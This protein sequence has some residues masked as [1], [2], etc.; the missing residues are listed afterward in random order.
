MS[1]QV[2]EKMVTWVKHNVEQSP[3]LKEM[4]NYVGYSSYYCSREFKD[5]TGMTYKKYLSNCKLKAIA[6]NLI[7]GDERITDLAHRY[8]YSSSEVLS[9]AFR[10]VYH[11]SPKEY[12]E[13]YR[14]DFI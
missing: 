13:C 2:K 9:R 6:N 12:R 1:T 10:M 5:H 11:K 4:A 3:S 14:V 7:V 8:G